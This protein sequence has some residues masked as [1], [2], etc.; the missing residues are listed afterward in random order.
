MAVIEILLHA[1]GVPV[2]YI[3]RVCGIPDFDICFHVS[4]VG[5]CKVGLK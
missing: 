3:V 1:A 5:Y 4:S 2:L